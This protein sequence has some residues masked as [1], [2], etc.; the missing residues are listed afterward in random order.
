[1]IRTRV[2]VKTRSGSGPRSRGKY[3][4]GIDARFARVRVRTIFE[5]RSEDRTRVHGICDFEKVPT[6]PKR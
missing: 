6:L 2:R 5:R 1:M 3:C 4:F